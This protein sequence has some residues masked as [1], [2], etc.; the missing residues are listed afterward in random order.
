MNYAT[1]RGGNTEEYSLDRLLLIFRKVCDAIAFAHSREI[2]HRDL[3]PENI[4]VGEFGEVLVMD[5]GLAKKLE[6]NPN[7]EIDEAILPGR[8]NQ[9]ETLQGDVM[10]TPQYMSPEQ[11]AG[12]ISALDERSDIFSLGG[13][14]YAI[15]TLRP[16][17]DGTTLHEVLEKVKTA[18]IEAPSHTTAVH[19]RNAASG[20]FSGGVLEA[21]QIKPLPH[22]PTGRVPPALSSVVMKALQREKSDRYPNVQEF[23][24]DVEA[25]QGGFATSA[26][27]INF[28]GQLALLIRRHKG[29]SIATA[30]GLFLIVVL[31]AGFMFKVNAEKQAALGAEALAEQ[32]AED[33]ARAEAQQKV[34]A[35]NA[36]A[37]EKDALA[38]LA[39]SHISLA[40]AAYRVHD[41]AGMSLALKECP[42]EYRDHSWTY[43]SDKI[44]SSIGLVEFPQLNDLH[45]ALP[46]PGKPGHFVLAGSDQSLFIV[47]VAGESASN[48]MDSHISG[49]K[50]LAV[51]GDGQT[52]AIGKRAGTELT[53][54]DIDTNAVLREFKAKGNSLKSI[55]LD[56]DGSVLAVGYLSAGHSGGVQVFDIKQGQVKCEVSETFPFKVILHPTEEIVMVGNMISRSLELYSTSNGNKYFSQK[57][58]LQSMALSHDGNRLAIGGMVGLVT[59]VDSRTGTQLQQGILQP[60]TVKNLA[61]TAENAIVTMGAP[62][63]GIWDGRNLSHL[64]S[65]YGLIRDSNATPL[66]TQLDPASGYMM[67]LGSKIQL[68]QIP[69]D[70]EVS[71]IRSAAEQA[72]SGCFLSDDTLIAAYGWTARPFDMTDPSTPEPLSDKVPGGFSVVACDWNTG[73]FAGATGFSDTGGLKLFEIENDTPSVRWTQ[74]TS[75]RARKLDFD[76]NS[77]RLLASDGS[78][79][80]IFSVADGSLIKGFDGTGRFFV[81]ENC[82]QIIGFGKGTNTLQGTRYLVELYDA[83]TGKPTRSTPMRS[84]PVSYS[85]SLDRKLAAQAGSDYVVNILDTGT[86]EHLISFRAHDNE[87]GALA[88]HPTEAMIASGSADGSLKLWDIK[89]GRLLRQFMGMRGTPLAIAFSP[90]GH[91][92][93]AAGRERTVRIFDT[94]RLGNPPRF[95]VPGSPPPE[96]TPEISGW[97]QTLDSGLPLRK[98]EGI[99]EIS[100][101]A[102]YRMGPVLQPGNNEHAAEL[103]GGD[104]SAFSYAFY[105]KSNLGIR[106]EIMIRLKEPST[107]KSILVENMRTSDKEYLDRA[108][109]LTLWFSRDG[110]KWNRVWEANQVDSQWNIDLKGGVQAQ[111]LKLGLPANGRLHLREVVVF[112]ESHKKV[113]P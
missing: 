22:I 91:L 24:T 59:I 101:D 77:E 49:G 112:G 48:K 73:K 12:D 86:L 44:D 108:A 99:S 8:E 6:E 26:E 79:N 89:T 104:V 78:R 33:A 18:E 62:R 13:I 72:H 9:A 102:E 11:A 95:V 63:V 10:G 17:V 47:D 36:R 4:M 38:S 39:R 55:S 16:P 84:R 7:R 56:H 41:V 98:H 2:I 113:R 76:V 5:W 106:P 25:F 75:F 66:D 71:K 57:F 80:Q 50:V 103:M 54:L 27:N 105:C 53:V 107:I 30:V 46:I 64:G 3:K 20:Q 88:F 45:A 61:W 94:S 82:T 60:G 58:E 67:T 85:I 74:S 15:L 90:S 31:S 40:E 83:E 1:K 109:G 35:D 21:R 51:S 87:I 34:E 68:W 93:Y 69:V 32:K 92:L 23:G 43:L 110:N 52:I 81:G 100:R 19:D 96:A 65:L 28:L 70:L 42:E 29:I 37:A 111:Y 97:I 14:L